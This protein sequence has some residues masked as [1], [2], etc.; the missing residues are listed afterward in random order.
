M[1]ILASIFLAVAAGLI[2]LTWPAPAP[3]RAPTGRE[4]DLD[5]AL[6]DPIAAV[7]T[8]IENKHPATYF[9]LARRLFAGGEK[10]DAVFWFYVGLIRYRSHLAGPGCQG[11]GARFLDLW[12]AVERPIND[13]AFGDI[14]RLA[15]AIGRALVWD[16]MHADP[17]APRGA[18]REEVRSG[19][20]RLKAEVLARQ[21]AL[22]AARATG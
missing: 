12:E 17:Y 9:I 7:K 16:D 11:E 2:F 22:R 6:T 5:A 4:S 3:R 1:Y 10:D 13:H 21:D 18:A 14:P 15:A 19:L 8:Q 20:R